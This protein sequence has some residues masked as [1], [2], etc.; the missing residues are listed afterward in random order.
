[1]YLAALSRMFGDLTL[2]G[3]TAG[4]PALIEPKKDV[5]VVLMPM[6]I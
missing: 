1:M 6:L 3:N 2:Q 5:R 4:D